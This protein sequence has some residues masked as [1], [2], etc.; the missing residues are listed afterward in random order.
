[1]QLVRGTKSAGDQIKLK[2]WRDA[3]EI[4][5]TATLTRQE[6][7]TRLVPTYSFGK[8]PNFLIKG[9]LIFQELT[10][11]LLE[12]YGEDWQSDAPLN[13]LDALSNPE[14]YQENHD[15]MICLTAVIPTQA[16]VGYESLRNMIISKV[17]GKPVRN[18]KDMIQAFSKPRLGS[19]SHSIEFLEENLI[20]HLD[21]QLSNSIDQALLTRGLHNLSRA[22]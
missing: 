19:T 21:E 18:M 11:P 5:V 12:A 1:M 16:T 17:N 8:A 15:R 10:R 2:V 20:V 14:K 3:N 22:E 7:S 4:E 6:E 13:Y 9:G